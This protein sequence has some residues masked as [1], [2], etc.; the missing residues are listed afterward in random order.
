MTT[1]SKAAQTPR[2]AGIFTKRRSKVLVVS[3]ATIFCLYLCYL[4]AQ[5]F[6][7]ALTWAVAAAIV[8]QG[9]V[10][11]LSRR[12]QSPSRRASIA[13]SLVTLV[14]FV[15]T[16]SL[17]YFAALEILGTLKNSEPTQFL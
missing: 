13:T 14:L 3:A 17:I 16:I 2:N 11:W 5:P 12:I 15:P 8:T 10:R 1:V 4:L 7:P 9:F 6:I